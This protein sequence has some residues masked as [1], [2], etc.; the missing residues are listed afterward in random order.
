MRGDLAFVG[1]PGVVYAPQAA[2]RVPGVVFGHDWLTNISHYPQTLSHLASWGM[3]VAAPDTQ[4]SLMPSVLNF[5]AD[6]GRTLDSVAGVALGSGDVSVHPDKLGLA[7]HGFGASAAVF[8]AAGLAG[9]TLR[10]RAVAAVFPALTAPSVLQP[11]VGLDLP[12]MVLSTSD[13]AQSLRTHATDVARVWDTS[14]LRVVSASHVGDVAENRRIARA[15]GLP[16]SRRSVQK[17]VRILLTGYLLYRLAGNRTYRAFA[18]PDVVL[19]HTERA[20]L[21]KEPVSLADRV[22]SLLT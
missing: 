2:G 8:A 1:I 17:A 4:R 9:S 11:A 12:G 15:L 3:V 16:G 5:A 6:L 10:P 18:D 19:P 22:V 20:D 7:G 13:D 14:V 21:H